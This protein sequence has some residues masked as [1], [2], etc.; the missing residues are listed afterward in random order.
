MGDADIQLD[1]PA[2]L[3]SELLEERHVGELD[4]GHH[5]PAAEGSGSGD[6]E[7]DQ[8]FPEAAGAE[9]LEDREAIPLP[10][11]TARIQGE[12]AHRARRLRRAQ[13]EDP[14]GI[15]LCVVAVSVTAS[16][17]LLLGHEHLVADAVVPIELFGGARRDDG[18]RDAGRRH[19]G[20]GHQ[21]LRVAA[22]LIERSTVA[23]AEH[24]WHRAQP[25]VTPEVSSP[26]AMR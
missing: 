4:V 3:P 16:E 5:L 12:Q 11:L 26:R 25:A 19:P 9:L 18:N 1:W 14:D 7:A 2:A 6:G 10:P 20:F 21:P 17:K 23:I 8:R 22:N 24:A 15:G 13:P